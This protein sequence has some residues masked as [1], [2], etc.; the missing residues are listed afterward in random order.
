MSPEDDDIFEAGGEMPT[1]GVPIDPAM[2]AQVVPLHPE[3]MSAQPTGPTINTELDVAEIFVKRHSDEFRYCDSLGG[4]F[5]W[6]GTH[7][8]RDDRETARECVKAIAREIASEAAATFDKD[9]FRVAKRAGSSAGVGAI[10]DLAR[11]APAIV[12]T[13][14]EANRDPWLLNVQNGTLD[15]RTGELRPHSRGD[16]IT[17]CCPVDYRPDAEAPTFERFLVEVQPN[18]D[19]RAYLARLFGYAAVGVVREHVIAVFWGTGANGKSVLADVVSHVLGSYARPG[20][21]SLIVQTGH[22]EPH[23]TD[24]AS[25]IGA[26][27][28]M[29]HE[30]KRG[31]AFD[32]S[33]VKLL[34]GGDKLT[35]RYMRQ[36]FVVFTPSHTLLMLTNYRPSADATDAALWRRVQLVPFELVVPEER[37]D[38]TLTAKIIA[39]AAGVLRWLVEGALEWQQKGLAP[40]AIVREQTAMYRA[41]EDVIGAFLDERCVRLPAATAKAQTLYDAFRA[42]C[43]ENGHSAVRVNDFADEVIARGFRREKTKAGNLYRGIG[44]V[45]TD[46]GDDVGRDGEP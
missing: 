2:L 29:V 20:P 41:S 8:E 37:R 18:A 23:P 15:L 19:V 3:R 36:D 46:R 42:W 28:V 13:A 21:S 24:V 16:L 4:W 1:R 31:A 44:L 26:R 6:T 45:A 32:A 40:P 33:K 7:Y 11:S 22:H 34:T 14:D 27:L 35:A 17:R 25:C 10:L 38:P 12:F 30:T 39:E 5:A 43:G 9:L